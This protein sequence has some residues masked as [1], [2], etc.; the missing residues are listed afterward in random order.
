MR[1][2]RYS[3]LVAAA[4][5]LGACA[6]PATLTVGSKNF[7][8]S[9]ILGE[10]VAQHLESRGYTVDRRLNLGGTFICHQAITSGQLDLY[11]EYTGTAYAAV[12]ELPVERDAAR[13]QAVVDSTYAARWALELTEPLGFNNTFAMLVRG[14]DAR[15][16]E[17]TTISD[18]APHASQ[19]RPGFGYEFAERADGFRGLLRTYDLEFASAPA[20][21]DLGLIYRALADGQV[22]IIAGNS[23]DG[24]IDALD[25]VHLRDDRD[26]FPPYQ[27]V[28]IVRRAALE[29][30]PG[31][32]DA[33]AA[34][35]GTIDEATM[36]SLNREVDVEKR[37]HR[38]VVRAFLDGLP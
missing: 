4:I 14:T 23:T 11:V 6:D 15:R 18:I 25:L 2:P 31:L 12:L 16:L 20:V 38:A 30:H 22:D 21:M 1:L 35:G 7:T 32:R 17:L 3:L 28:P 9:V 29:R 37:D 34:L 8:E 27:A 13:V 5:C 26:Y 19:W 24:Q 33:L 10:L 36:R